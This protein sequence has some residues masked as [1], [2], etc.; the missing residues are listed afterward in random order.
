VIG[1]T[2]VLQEHGGMKAV[3]FTPASGYSMSPKDLRAAVRCHP[4]LA[5]MLASAIYGR[6]PVPQPPEEGGKQRIE[7]RRARRLE[8]KLFGKVVEMLSERAPIRHSAE[9]GILSFGQPGAFMYLVRQGRVR[10]DVAGR[11]VEVIAPGGI[12]GEGALIDGTTRRATALAVDECELLPIDRNSLFAIVR[13][14]PEFA[15]AIFEEAVRRSAHMVAVVQA[16]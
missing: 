6:C 11:T 3:A 12:F 16:C 9:R 14:H 2:A 7:P 8:P 15:L 13:R 10:V 1:E 4:E 5:L